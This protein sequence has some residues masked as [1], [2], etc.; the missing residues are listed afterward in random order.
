M[1]FFVW[2]NDQQ[3]G[4]FEEEIIRKMLSEKQIEQDTLVCPEGGDLDWISIK[5]LFFQ[6]SLPE[7]FL[8]TLSV[9]EISSNQFNDDCKLII[10]LNS[11]TELKVK[12]IRLFDEIELAK[13]NSKKAKAMEMLKG[14]ST[15]IS[16][17][18]SI[19]C[20][21]AASVAIGAVESILSAST[22]SS[23]THLLK[24]ALQAEKQLRKEGVLFPVSKIQYVD[25]SMPGLW[26]AFARK[27]KVA[28][29]FVHNGDDFISVRTDNDSIYSIRWSAV[30]SN[31]YSKSVI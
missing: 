23:G 22:A 30:E 17:W 4:P 1:K 2:L 15:G 28:M 3:Q 7:S 21:L 29:A 26:R 5:E 16:A 27:S 13:L 18:G 11:G 20:V 10:R 25:T 24:E 31:F 12:A 19:E 9:E 14:I 8:H 6:E